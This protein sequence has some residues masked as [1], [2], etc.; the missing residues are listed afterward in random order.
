MIVPTSIASTAKKI[1]TTAGSKGEPGQMRRFRV[2][3]AGDDAGHRLGD[4]SPTPLAI[5]WYGRLH[6]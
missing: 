5:L 2:Q 4:R 3:L 6:R 1:G